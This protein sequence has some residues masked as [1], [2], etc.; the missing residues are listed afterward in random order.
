MID[1]LAPE[2]GQWPNLWAA[3]VFGLGSLAES[4]P[5][6]WSAL[7]AAWKG[8]AP[9]LELPVTLRE[10]GL[11]EA[12]YYTTQTPGIPCLR[13]AWL[14]LPKTSVERVS[15]YLPSLPLAGRLLPLELQRGFYKQLSAKNSFQYNY[16]YDFFGL[17]LKRNYESS[18]AGGR[19]LA[20]LWLGP[21]LPELEEPD[22]IFASMDGVSYHKISI[23]S[24][25][26]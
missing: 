22:F 20:A 24:K 13:N 25:L 12:W 4:P 21:L 5:D 1:H 14:V 9:A 2:A 3:W 6:P 19:E 7:E 18:S 15:I 8:E 10:A 23:N 11:R 26:E 16:S 17:M